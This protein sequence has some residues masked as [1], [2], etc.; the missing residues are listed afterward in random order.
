MH[1]PNIVQS[2]PIAAEVEVGKAYHWCA[3]KRTGKRPL[4][5][6]SHKKLAGVSE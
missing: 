2:S 6:G 3:C 5:N 1:L 4:C